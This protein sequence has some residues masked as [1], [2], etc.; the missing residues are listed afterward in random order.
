MI[1]VIQSG[2]VGGH[3]GSPFASSEV[4]VA[5]GKSSRGTIAFAASAAFWPSSVSVSARVFKERPRGTT[6]RGLGRSPEFLPAARSAKAVT[7]AH[8]TEADIL[9]RARPHE[10]LCSKP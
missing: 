6:A 10:S 4:P 1:V 2:A 3:V 5:D 7:G 9:V 8:T